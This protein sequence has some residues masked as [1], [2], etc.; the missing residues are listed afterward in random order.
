[1]Q[2]D[3]NTEGACLSGVRPAAVDLADVRDEVRLDRPGLSENPSQ[4]LE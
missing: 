2:L 3:A 4:P 1:V